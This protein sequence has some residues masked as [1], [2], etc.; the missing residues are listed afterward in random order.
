MWEKIKKWAKETALPWIK[1]G[2]MHIVNILIV[3]IAYGQLEGG[4]EWLVGLWAFIL[5]GYYIFWKFFGAEKVIKDYIKQKKKQ[6]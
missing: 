4:N 3:L 1:K 5:I 2:W 6:K